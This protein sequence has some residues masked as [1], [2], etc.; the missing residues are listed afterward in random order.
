M[1]YM[2]VGFFLGLIFFGSATLGAGLLPR[3]T[4]I[5][6]AIGSRCIWSVERLVS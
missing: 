6:M 5:F 3:Q 1:D 2:I 4:G